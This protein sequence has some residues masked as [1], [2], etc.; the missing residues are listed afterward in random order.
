VEAALVS[1]MLSYG[2]VDEELSRSMRADRIFPSPWRA[3]QFSEGY[4]V[5]DANNCVLAYVVAGEQIA[6]AV[7]RNGLSL[8]EAS[9]IARVIAGLPEL[10]P[11]TPAHPK[12]WSWSKWLSP[13]EFYAT[14]G[15]FG[16]R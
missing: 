8:E 16:R 15:F 14:S 11:E 2:Q 7:Q 4:C 12:Q 9:R 3:E 13:R 10:I 6:D 5:L 1:E